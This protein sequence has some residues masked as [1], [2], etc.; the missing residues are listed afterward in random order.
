VYDT[1][2]GTRQRKKHI[3]GRQEDY[4]MDRLNTTPEV[5]WDTH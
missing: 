4:S 1:C 2:T 5:E 3:G